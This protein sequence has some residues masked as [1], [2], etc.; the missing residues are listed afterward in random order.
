MIYEM[1]TYWPAPGKMGAL[2]ARFRDHTI[3]LFKKH[4]IEVVGFWETYIGP[5]PSLIY[6]LGYRDLGHR[7][8]AWDAFGSDP[9]WMKARADSERDGALVARLEAV[10]MRGSSYGPNA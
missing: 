5:G 3:A 7:E 8:T 4:E 6:V 10:I 9:E 1:R 2:N